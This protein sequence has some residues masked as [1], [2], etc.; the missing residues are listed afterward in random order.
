MELG[1][2]RFAEL[3]REAFARHGLQADVTLERG[4]ALARAVRAAGERPDTCVVLAGGDGTISRLLPHLTEARGP[5]AILPLGTLNLLAR[6]LGFDGD[7]PHDIAIIAAGHMRQVDIAQLND[8][9]F[10]SNAGLGFFAMMARE[11]ENARIR[12]PFSKGLG[13]GWAAMRTVLFSRPVLVDL[14]V[15][16]DRRQIQADAV[17]VTNNRFDGTPWLRARLD[18][19]LLEVHLLQAPTLRARLSAALAVLRGT[20][21]E[22]PT[23]TS[24]ECTDL[25]LS[26]RRRRRSSVAVDG[27]VLRLRGPFRFS[28]SRGA[29]ALAGAP[30]EAPG[31]QPAA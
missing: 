2:D 4:E 5:V 28:V 9:P 30:P 14:A 31:E 11:R 13:F 26:R 21:R 8:V 24:I 29:L 10:H 18:E 1:P 3:V 20:W 27:E 12:F 19:G 25:T 7:I 15:E 17:L 23:L 6:D 16:G 22:L